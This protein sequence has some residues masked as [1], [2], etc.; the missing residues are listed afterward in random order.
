M[1]IVVCVKEV[2]DPDAVDAYALSGGL[3]I[4]DDGTSI[5]QSTIP[6]LMN[7]YD[8]QA[9]EAAL[10]IRDAG[11]DCTVSVVSLGAD[12]TALLRHALALGADD[13]SAIEPPTGGGDHHV[14]AA[15]LAAF[16]RST[17]GADLVLCG[18]Q[19]SDDDQ[20][21]VPALIATTLE[22]PLI[23]VA[24]RVEITTDSG[25]PAVRVLRVTPEGA[26]TVQAACP[27]VVTVSSELGE[28]RY[29]TMPQKMAARRITPTVVDPQELPVE[30]G[31]RTSR[32]V[33]SRQYVPIVKGDCELITGDDAD[34]VARTLIARL[35]EDKALRGR[36]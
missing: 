35:I 32:A 12:L 27:A 29:P 21:V 20:G 9:I 5:T 26:E 10:R 3:V 13:A 22:L 8:E 30:P 7:G 24:Q 16:I 17:G 33:L 6:R 31:G 23:T 11:T 25:A 34:H 18:R 1:R 28:P 15:L 19:A 4:G 2:L 36:T 14:V